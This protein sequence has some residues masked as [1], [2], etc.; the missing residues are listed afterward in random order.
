VTATRAP[1]PALVVLLLSLAAIA[2]RIEAALRP[3]LW[4]DEIFSLA[5]ATGH[6]LEHAATD[7]DSTHG[8]FVQPQEAQP[9]E[10]FRRYA[11]AETPPASAGR[12]IRAV[13]LSDTSPPLYYLILGGWIRAFG[14]GDA[15]LRLFSVWWAALSVPLFWLIGREIG[16][17]RV[18][19]AAC[20]L[21]SFS[22]VAFFYSVE[23]RMY[24]LLW[25]LALALGWLT[26][27]LADEGRPWHAALWVM[28]GAAG[29]LTHYFFSFVWVAS[30]A[31]LCL[32]GSPSRR[33]AIA[34]VVVTLLAVLPWYL[35]VPASMARWRVS[36][37][38]LNGELSWR[39]AL[40]R[41]FTLAGSLLSGSSFLGG[42]LRA[43]RLVAGL[44]LLVVAWMAYRRS[45]RGIWSPRCLLLW[46]WLAA[47]CTGPLV[48]D[49]LRH[50][51]TSDVPRYVL[52][53]LPAA[54]LLA[55][56]AMS[57]L[58]PRVHIAFIAAVLLAWLP[59]VAATVVA[60]TPRPWEP[61]PEVAAHL[62]SWAQPGDVVLIRS[63]PSGVVGVARYLE[64]DIPVAAWVDALG[65]QT[66]PTD[67]ER[68]L[69]GHHRVAVATIHNLGATDQVEPW[70]RAHARLTGH[71]TFRS[72][73]AEVL[74]FEPVGSAMLSR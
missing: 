3:G 57:Q 63:I 32:A 31:W 59:G 22:P 10:T 2:L 21:F 64:R 73:S 29:L 23:G 60:K 62:Q 54:V 50:T 67:L 36:G 26:M 45:I 15:A 27:R 37:G 12:V 48:F 33:R 9:P 35:Q 74:Y 65:T 70:L 24:S 44:L 8:D 55:A 56:V 46:G 6:S 58:P 43:N 68:L 61:F 72:S 14:G 66:V 11:E 40:G 41:P 17:V 18:A 38:W 53:G 19:G 42:W 25:F 47:A 7:A 16:G 30:V 69:Q 51:T 52:A 39:H 1:W 5:M 28:A 4:A 34:L 71:A 13:L 49:L 20:V